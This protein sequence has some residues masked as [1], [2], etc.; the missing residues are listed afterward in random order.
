MCLL[1]SVVLSVLLKQNLL[2]F[3]LLLHVCAC[4]C[5]HVHMSVSAME[6]REGIESPRVGV[7]GSY[8]S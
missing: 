6:A 3:Y 7:T 8:G 5:A 1:I 4:A 2:Y